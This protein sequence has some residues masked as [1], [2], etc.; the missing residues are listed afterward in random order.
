MKLAFFALLVMAQ[1]CWAD[2]T[3]VQKIEGANAMPDKTD[4]IAV[5]LKGEK[6]R[7]EAGS[8]ISIIIDAKT[9]E[10]LTLMHDQK[11]IVRISSDRAKAMMEMTK[12][13][14]G[15]GVDQ[16]PKLVDTGRKETVNGFATE[17]Y[18]SETPTGKATYWIATN[19]PHAAEILRQMQAMQPGQWNMSGHGI[20]DLRDLPGLPIKTQVNL[21]GKEITSSV[22]SIKEDPLPESDFVA[23]SDYTEMKLPNILSGAKTSTAAPSVSPSPAATP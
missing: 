8:R 3:L 17:I 2:V 14:Q 23:P 7:I 9:G 18:T 13:F 11:Q 22:T 21:N 15:D 20:P 12:K 16:K 5:K 1:A 6:S 19:Y 4:E 10:M